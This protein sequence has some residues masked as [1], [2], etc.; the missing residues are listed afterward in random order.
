[1]AVSGNYSDES[2]SGKSSVTWIVDSGCSKN[3][4]G[5]PE[6]LTNVRETD[7]ELQLPNGEKIRATRRGE[8]K[9]ETRVEGE[10]IKLT[11]QDVLYV[12]GLTKNLLSYGTLDRKNIRLTYQGSQRY[13]ATNGIKLAEVILV[14]KD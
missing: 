3:L 9:M 4:V 10:T 1:M 12:P 8:V 14:T 2:T 7:V 6:L 11:I 5:R 13:L